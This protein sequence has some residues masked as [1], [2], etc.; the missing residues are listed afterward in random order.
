MTWRILAVN[1]LALFVLV[2]GILYLGRYK[3]ELIHSEL[4]AM[5]VQAEMYAAALST[6]AVSS[7]DDATNQVKLEVAREMVR[8]LVGITGAR[9][10]LFAVNGNLIADSRNIKSFGAGTIQAEELP[11]PGDDDFF[12]EVMRNLTDGLLALFEGDQPLPL[13][14]D[15]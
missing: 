9:T 11:A 13:Y 10:R 12:A 14:V 8:R 3:Q 1:A 4:E 7:G 5:A 6:S 2:A 15:P